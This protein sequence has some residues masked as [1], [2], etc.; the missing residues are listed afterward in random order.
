MI[1]G[2]W[3]SWGLTI[4]VSWACLMILKRLA[5]KLGLVDLPG[6]R[7]QHEGIIPVVGGL[8]LFL[9][10]T[11][12][13]LTL[14]QPLHLYR[15]FFASSIILIL[16][17]LADDL[18][19]ISARWRLIGQV[20]VAAIVVGWGGAF[21]GDLGDLIGTGHIHLLVIGYIISVIAIVGFINAFNMLDGNDGLSGSLALITLGFIALLA[22]REGDYY[23]L[24]PV[25]LLCTAIAVFLLFNF[26]LGRLRASIFMGDVGSMILGFA[27]AW[28][29]VRLSQGGQALAQPAT[30][31]WLIAV[32]LYDCFNV[33]IKR[34]KNGLSPMQAGREH[35]HHI[36]IDQ[37]Y[38]SLA[39]VCIID[40]MAIILGAIGVLLYEL[41][42]PEVGSFA[43]FL[44]GF[45]IYTVYCQYLPDIARLLRRPRADFN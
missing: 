40:F 17:G 18:H 42:V 10:F 6:G 8:A 34:L 44:L 15:A 38:G 28:Y 27:I 4:V 24:Y 1:N 12:G 37:G 30:F 21:L 5:P 23:E 33:I 2:F 39:V 43:L 22:W 3:V 29:C 32:P 20:L 14:A 31:L 7:K 19:E 16:L 13:C 35:I 41:G 25:L 11:I 36:L 26:P 45:I 9:G